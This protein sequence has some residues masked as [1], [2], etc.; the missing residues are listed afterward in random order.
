MP[1]YWSGK[2]NKD[3][4]AAIIHESIH[5]ILTNSG[6]DKVFDHDAYREGIDVFFH[7]KS[8]LFLGYYNKHFWSGRDIKNYWQAS[9][10][11]WKEFEN[12][13]N[14]N[15]F[16][17]IP[18]IL[19]NPNDERVRRIIEKIKSTWPSSRDFHV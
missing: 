15:D 19:L 12:I 16:K 4:H 2:I 3:Q 18:K 5:C 11:F 17:T 9:E 6:V 13:E 7:R 1:W 14:E 10:F 8:S